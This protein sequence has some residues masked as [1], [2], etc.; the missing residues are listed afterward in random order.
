MTVHKDVLGASPETPIVVVDAERLRDNIRRMAERVAALG[1]AL[2]P[3]AKTHKMPSVAR[4]QLEAGAVGITVAK[5]SEA[6]TMAAGG[7]RDLFVAFPIVDPRKL[8]RVARLSER[9]TLTLGVDSH[10]GAERAAAAAARNG[11]RLSVRLEVDTGLRRTGVAY[12]AAPALAVRLSAME[13]LDFDGI[14]TFRGSWKGG[15]ATL[16]AEAAGLEEGR[17]MA[18]LAERIRAAGVPVRAVSVGSTPTALYAAQV[19]GVTEVRPGTYAFYDR[20]QLRLGACAPSDVAA[21]V[22]VTV[23]SRPAPDYVVVDGGSKTFATDVP[24]GTVPLRLEGFGAVEELPHAVLERL[25]EEHGV[26]RVRPDDDIRVGDTLH[27]VPNHI[28]STINLHAGVAWLEDG[29]MRIVPV[30]ARGMLA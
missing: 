1:V 20:M 10:E 6:E 22:R 29:D 23:V 25:S 2:R 16:D 11:V 30:A 17:L 19:P 13:S 18:S 9:A 26:L 24:P 15:A 5:L 28:C 14:Y 27:I 3:H 12:E 21:K 7:I 8:D 4:M